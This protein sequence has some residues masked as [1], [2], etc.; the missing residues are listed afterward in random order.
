M[1]TTSLSF[2][3]FVKKNITKLSFVILC[4]LGVA[5]IN[6]FESPFL[7]SSLLDPIVTSSTFLTGSNNNQLYLHSHPVE[8]PR[9][10]L[11]LIHGLGEHAGRYTSFYQ[12]FNKLGISVY[13]LDYEGHGKTLEMNGAKGRTRVAVRYNLIMNMASKSITSLQDLTVTLR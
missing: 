3:L 13:A 11:A 1:S 12:L 8:S 2:L 6:M 7:P 4:E 5:P 10:G 9:A